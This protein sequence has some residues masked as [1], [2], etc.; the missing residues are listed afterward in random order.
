MKKVGPI[1]TKIRIVT[2]LYLEPCI[3]VSIAIHP[4]VLKCIPTA[5]LI[6][7]TF[8]L[9][10]SQHQLLVDYEHYTILREK[11]VGSVDE[12]QQNFV[13]PLAK[14]PKPMDESVEEFSESGLSSSLIQQ[15]SSMTVTDPPN[16]SPRHPKKSAKP[17][18]LI[19]ELWDAP[20]FTE[21][22]TNNNAC[23][24][25]RVSLPGCES[26]S[27]C[28]VTVLPRDDLVQVECEKLHMRL[29]LE[30]KKRKKPT[31]PPN[32][33]SIFDIQRLTAKFVKK[34]QH[35]ILSIPILIETK[36]VEQKK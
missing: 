29:K 9:V 24:T 17:A 7:S 13:K 15:I 19:E 3:I 12:I 30:M 11:C 16:P 8:D 2:R 4:D 28:D 20:M 32:C 22:I 26:V 31:I 6:R 33:Q 34:T 27:D 36:S 10:V 35:L 23:L 18:V 14:K 25:V 1:E 21:E 5:Q